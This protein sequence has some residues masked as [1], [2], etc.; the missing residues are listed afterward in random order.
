MTPRPYMRF[1]RHD[2]VPVVRLDG[3]I[4]MSRAAD[5][6]AELAGAVENEDLGLVMELSEVSYLDSSAVTVLFE[7]SERLEAR[8]QV[9]A[10]VVPDNA[11]IKRVIALVGLGSVVRLCAG[12]PEAV[13]EVL[14]EAPDRHDLPSA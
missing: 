12:L 10:A 9:L 8:Q 1:E 5:V 7:L 13:G 6:R 3:E 14:G 4:D 2:G 11:L